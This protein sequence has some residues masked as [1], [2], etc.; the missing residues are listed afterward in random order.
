MGFTHYNGTLILSPQQHP[1]VSRQ[2][3]VHIEDKNMRHT[4]A[5]IAAPRARSAVIQWPEH[6]PNINE[7]HKQAVVERYALIARA[8]SFG[9][10]RTRTNYEPLQLKTTGWKIP[11]AHVSDC[12]SYTSC[13]YAFAKEVRASLRASVWMCDE[14]VQTEACPKK[15][16][17]LTT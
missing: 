15:S 12:S 3:A 13:T 11:A 4:R 14:H 7:V 6:C 1:T 16:Y 17:T 8:P 2:H 10:L 5:A 9:A